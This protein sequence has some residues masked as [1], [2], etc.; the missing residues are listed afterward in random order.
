[1]PDAFAADLNAQMLETDANMSASFQG[2]IYKCLHNTVTDLKYNPCPRVLSVHFA[3]RI[4]E[5]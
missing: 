4:K 2:C 1:M 3:F 5:H